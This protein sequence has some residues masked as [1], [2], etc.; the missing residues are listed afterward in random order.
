[1]EY[2]GDYSCISRKNNRCAMSTARDFL[3]LIVVI[4]NKGKKEKREKQQNQYDKSIYEGVF[5]YAHY[6]HD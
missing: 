3:F 4:S 5:K 2:A 1:M 6:I